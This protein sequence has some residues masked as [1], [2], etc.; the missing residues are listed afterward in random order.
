M[1]GGAYDDG[2]A[3]GRHD[4]LA[5]KRVWHNVARFG[6]PEMRLAG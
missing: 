4:E 2:P 1:F 6:S 5:L 3:A